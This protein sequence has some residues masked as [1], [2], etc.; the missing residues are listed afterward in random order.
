MLLDVAKVLLPFV[1]SFMIGIA[2][3]PFISNILYTNKLWKK[4]G[5]KVDASG[6]ETVEFNKIHTNRETST[7][8]MGGI[9]IWLSAT[10][11]TLSIWGLAVLMHD[12][13]FAKFDFLSRSQTWLPLAALL[14]GACV[15]LVDDIYEVKSGGNHIA[16]GLSLIQRLLIVSAMGLCAGAWFFF[17]LDV[18]EIAFLGNTTLELGYL[19]IPFFALVMVALY[20]GGVIDGIDG[21]AGGIFA[22]IFTAYAMIAFQQTQINLAAFSATMA[23]SILAFLW[24]NIPPARFYMSETGS[25]ALTTTLAVVAFMTDSLGG[26]EGVLLLPIIGFVLVVTVLSNIIQVVSKKFRGKKV[27]R[28]APLHHHF[29][30]IGWPSYKVTMR[31]WIINIMCAILGLILAILIL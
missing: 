30:A 27:L 26:G 2:L 6:K 22:T 29:E 13:A 5:G 18:S 8:R 12:P 21:L 24:F 11:T 25:M 3:T 16:G 9:I 20:A 1:T 31:Y 28:I 17:K 15:G 23:G 4:K 7:P 14:I 10:V 19:F